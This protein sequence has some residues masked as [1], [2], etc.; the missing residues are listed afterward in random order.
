MVKFEVGEKYVGTGFYG[1]CEMKV[2]KRMPK[3]IQFE[4]PFGISR[5]KL[6]DLYTDKEAISH[7]AWLYTAKI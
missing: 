5:S 3:M 7:K 6:R 1:H 2:L 4:T